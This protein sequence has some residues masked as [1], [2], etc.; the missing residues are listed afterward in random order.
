MIRL[1][2]SELEAVAAIAEVRKRGAVLLVSPGG[3]DI[4]IFP[5][6]KLPSALL[7]RLNQHLDSIR[8]ILLSRAMFTE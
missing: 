7:E 5:S 2:I 3:Q 1:N 6:G 8:A 4:V